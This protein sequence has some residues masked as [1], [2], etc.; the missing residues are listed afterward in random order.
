MTISLNTIYTRIKFKIS[1]FPFRC[2]ANLQNIRKSIN[3]TTFSERAKYHSTQFIVDHRL[4]STNRDSWSRN[5]ILSAFVSYYYFEEYLNKKNG[6]GIM[7]MYIFHNNYIPL[8]YVGIG[9]NSNVYQ[10][11]IQAAIREVTSL[12]ES[13]ESSMVSF[14]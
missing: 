1:L 9:T 7:K 10:I 5:D 3:Y 12:R 4:E 13:F 2:I 11:K 6:I 8:A 14:T